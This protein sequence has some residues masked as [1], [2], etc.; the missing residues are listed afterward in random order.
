MKVKHATVIA[1][2]KGPEYTFPREWKYVFYDEEEMREQTDD[3]H[4][5]TMRDKYGW[6]GIAGVT[7]ASLFLRPDVQYARRMNIISRKDILKSGIM[8]V[9]MF[10]NRD[11]A[12]QYFKDHCVLEQMEIEPRKMLYLQSLIDSTPKSDDICSICTDDLEP[13][14]TTATL[15]CHHTFCFSCVKRLVVSVLGR[16]HAEGVSSNF[17]LEC[18]NCRSSISNDAV[19]EYSMTNSNSSHSFVR[20]GGSSSS[21]SSSS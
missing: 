6:G 1:E 2:S 12:K 7:S 3:L 10:G 17:L 15:P 21:S 9:H 18:P 8:D 11:V 13:S 16:E 5:A 19:E 14:D 20:S 4:W